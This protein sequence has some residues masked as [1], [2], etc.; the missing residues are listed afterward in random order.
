MIMRVRAWAEVIDAS[1]MVLHEPSAQQAC[2]SRRNRTAIVHVALHNPMETA[3]ETYDPQKSSTE[4]S[5]ANP[6][7]MNLRALLFG[8]FG[9]IV[10]FAIVYMVFT[11]NQPNP[12]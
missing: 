6:R 12:T 1:L 5:Q 8:L 2:A 7:K 3:M 9:I 10:L 11:M 4:A